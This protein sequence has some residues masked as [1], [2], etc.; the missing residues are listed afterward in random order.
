MLESDIR[1]PAG[2]EVLFARNDYTNSFFSIVAGEV[3]V[4]LEAEGAAGGSGKRGVVLREGEYFGELGLISG[5]RRAAA[6]AVG[7]V[8][9]E[10]PRRSMLKL[11][12][13]VESVRRE[14][15][16]AFLRRSIR[17]Y[18]SQSLPDAV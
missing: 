3:D 5:R 2:G 7:C 8:L 18:L 9:I 13:S 15:D 16:Q 11:I 4:E 14:V 10:T 17:A 12:A 6:W 1:T